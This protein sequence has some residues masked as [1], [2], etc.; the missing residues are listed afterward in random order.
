MASEKARV[1]KGIQPRLAVEVV[2]KALMFVSQYLVLAGKARALLDG[3]LTV[4][5]E[6]IDNLARPTLR[7]R[8]LTNFQAEAQGITSDDLISQLLRG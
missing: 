2:R 6:D 5:T 3:R 7:H 4:A 1:L 8:M